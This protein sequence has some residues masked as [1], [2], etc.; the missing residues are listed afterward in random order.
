MTSTQPQRTIGASKTDSGGHGDAWVTSGIWGVLLAAMA[1]TYTLLDVSEVYSISRDGLDGAASRVLVPPNFPIALV[2]IA[3]LLTA[4]DV[5]D[6]HWWWAAGPAMVACAVRA[7]PGVVTTRIS[8][9][10]SST[11]SP[12][13]GWPPPSPSP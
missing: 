12:L 2:A 13:S 4:M 6:P 11:S 7:W 3:V 9:P 1:V 10:D 5:L 8:A